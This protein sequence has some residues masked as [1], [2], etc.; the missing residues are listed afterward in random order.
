MP[1]CV[2]GSSFGVIGF[3][4]N[5][6][7]ECGSLTFNV[8]YIITATSGDPVPQNRV[9]K[10]IIDEIRIESA[11]MLFFPIFLVENWNIHIVGICAFLFRS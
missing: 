1:T 6:L 2:L 8:L 7:K 5:R 4:G 3:T 9:N 10:A 11:H